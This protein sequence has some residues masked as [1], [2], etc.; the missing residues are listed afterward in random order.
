MSATIVAA[1]DCPETLLS[2]CIPLQD[3]PSYRYGKSTH[4][5]RFAHS[6]CKVAHN[7]QFDDLPIQL[8]CSDFLQNTREYMSNCCLAGRENANSQTK[9]THKVN[10]DGGYIAFGVS[11]V[12]QSD[13]LFS[14]QRLAR[15]S[16]CVTTAG[17]P[18]TAAADKTFPHR[19]HQ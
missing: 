19:S 13:I 7:L 10:T 15:R 18:Q 9:I 4:K 17:S 12:L 1:S 16:V 2:C 14:I 5:C 3:T 6:L 8:H 11:I